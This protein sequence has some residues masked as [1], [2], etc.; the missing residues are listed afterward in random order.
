MMNLIV[1][2]KM[3]LVPY[4]ESPADYLEEIELTVRLEQVTAEHTRLVDF[5]TEVKTYLNSKDLELASRVEELSAILDTINHE[6]SRPEVEVNVDEDGEVN[7]EEEDETDPSSGPAFDEAQYRKRCKNIYLLISRICHPDK[8]PNKHFHGL[9]M[10]AQQAYGILDL[11]ALQDILE[12]V[13]GSNSKIK[14]VRNRAREKISDRLRK[15]RKAIKN[16]EQEISAIVDNPDYIIFEVY[17]EH[18]PENARE[19]RKRLLVHNIDQLTAQIRI[20]GYDH[21]L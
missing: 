20:S 19:F 16:K 17:E 21:L 10:E 9:F 2:P 15:L 4:G 1:P 6:N 12:L 5:C 11:D 18:G 8:T 3:A 7:E 13:K 14:S